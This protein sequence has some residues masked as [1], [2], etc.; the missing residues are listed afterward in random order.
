MLRATVGSNATGN[1]NSR[2]KC[3]SMTLC[4]LIRTPKFLFFCSEFNIF[5]VLLLGE[6]YADILLGRHLN[7]NMYIANDQTC[8][9]N[10]IR[11]KL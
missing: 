7:I 1:G 3:S 8:L 10:A 6:I 4:H 2:T 11:I 9:L 5:S